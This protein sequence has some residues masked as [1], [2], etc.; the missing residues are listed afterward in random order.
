MHSKT[1]TRPKAFYSKV[2]ELNYT[3]WGLFKGY[4]TSWYEYDAEIGIAIQVFI[5]QCN[6]ERFPSWTLN[7]VEQEHG[8]AFVSKSPFESGPVRQGFSNFTE[9][10][11]HCM[12][13]KSKC[14]V[15]LNV[16]ESLS[17]RKGIVQLNRHRNGKIIESGF[18]YFHAYSKSKTFLDWKSTT[19][20][21]HIQTSYG[22]P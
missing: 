8:S 1:P 7:I 5:A 4:S 11:S 20:I 6:G 15:S 12:Q 14:K 17:K 2:I 16:F 3:H 10:R 21:S 19:T 22:K 13:R 18:S 9:S